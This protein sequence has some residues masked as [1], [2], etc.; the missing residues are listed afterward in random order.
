[1]QNEDKVIVKDRQVI[2]LHDG[3]KR[4]IMAQHKL[5]VTRWLHIFSRELPRSHLGLDIL[6][7]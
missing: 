3:K 1:M 7:K 2:C 5:R 4:L 6:E